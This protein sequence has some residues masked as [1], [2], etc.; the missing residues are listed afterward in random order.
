MIDIFYFIWMYYTYELRYKHIVSPIWTTYKVA[1]WLFKG[2]KASV[3]NFVPFKSGNKPPK[4]K[5]INQ[6]QTDD[7]NFI[8]IDMKEI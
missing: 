2:S 4:T 7:D 6:I 1:S 3:G 8:N 5:I